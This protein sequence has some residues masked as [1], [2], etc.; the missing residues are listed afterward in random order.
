L[1]SADAPQLS[2]VVPACNSSETIGACLAALAS[3]EFRGFEVI[4][5]DDGSDDKTAQV[6]ER[7][8]VRVV[9]HRINR[10]RSAARAT[11]FRYAR[12]SVIVCVDSDIVVSTDALG[13][14]SNHFT[15]TPD[16]TVISGLLSESH[17]VPNLTSQYL[18]LRLNY[19]YSH[20]PE[21]IP[22]F[23]GGVFAFRRELE[24]Y[25]TSRFEVCEDT[26]IGIRLAMGSTE[27]V[28]VK[29]LLVSH[30]KKF[31]IFSFIDAD[32]RMAMNWARL[33]FVNRAWR[34][35]FSSPPCLEQLF[36]YILPIGFLVFLS[37]KRTSRFAFRCVPLAFA[38]SLTIVMGGLVGIGAYI[39]NH[40]VVEVVR[41]YSSVAPVSGE[42][43]AVDK[44]DVC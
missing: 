39:S 42:L 9:R 7:L 19:L 24:P 41:R 8:G 1:L 31:D 3:S 11:G 29:K 4:V 5:V 37:R 26:D 12:G 38:Q 33:F 35:L 40:L 27:T 28:L 13:L 6:A 44:K 32:F 18:N 2:V 43:V 21:R 23:Y 15:T 17:P 10:G 16:C 34:Y 25:F 20:L 30:L 14:I 36:R 22:F